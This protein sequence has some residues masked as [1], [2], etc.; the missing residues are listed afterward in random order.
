MAYT[1]ELPKDKKTRED[2][3]GNLI[4][5]GK[6]NRNQY[7][8][9]WSIA[10]HYLQGV[11]NFTDFDYLNGEVSYKLFEDL[12][13]F[14]N[15]SGIEH[16]VELIVNKFQSQAGRLMGMDFAPS[17]EPLN[18]GIESG[19]NAIVAETILRSI[20]NDRKSAQLKFEAITALLAY[21]TIGLFP[22]AAEENT[23]FGV[24][25]APPWE[26]LP[27]PS[28]ARSGSS[29]R[30]I[31]RRR[32]TPLQ[33]VKN[34][35]S[36]KGKHI[37]W[38]EVEKFS[39]QKGEIT[40]GLYS[41]SLLLNETDSD[42]GLP[43]KET[44]DTKKAQDEIVE[45]A[46]VWMYSDDNHLKT[47]TQWVGGLEIQHVDY[48]QDDTGVGKLYPA[49]SI[50]RYIDT[51]SFW[52]RGFVELL[53]PTNENIEIMSNT[54]YNNV[55]QID[56]F[57]ILCL[58]SSM[59]INESILRHQDGIKK[60][61]FEPDY[62]VPQAKPFKISP[63]NSG[64]APVKVMNTAL[65]FM[66]AIANQPIELMR[67]DAPGRA[68]SSKSLGFLMESAN[69]P[70]TPS[71]FSLSSSVSDIYRFFLSHVRTTWTG[72]EEINMPILN[73]NISGLEIDNKTGKL[74]LKPNSIPHPDEV[75]VS[76]AS[77]KPV[78]Q[79]QEIMMLQ[80]QM[81]GGVITPMEYRIEMRKRNLPV[82]VA[83]EQEWQNYRKQTIENMRQ[84]NDGVTPN[85]V[86]VS[87]IDMHEVHLY[88]IDQFMAR[89]EFTLASPSVREAF[90][91]HRNF[92]LDG[93]G[94]MP[95]GAET[96][97]EA[98]QS[99]IEYRQEAPE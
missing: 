90:I 79:Q 13:E 19:K 2:V 46:E 18:I 41:E 66:D 82:P 14:G 63:T 97:E 76:I 30:G 10:H 83:N 60:I 32:N 80:E 27:V 94:Q 29:T 81:S 92:H 3:I 47:Y 48:E 87:D 74:T 64:D 4:S 8:V 7:L 40:S 98:A 49:C 17:V 44:I 65:A 68:D 6:Q 43:R 56:E 71:A 99:Y 75:K 52:G 51:G 9:R 21:G 89:P 54:L 28:T 67:G 42:L 11:R 50:A 78:N 58:P 85:K 1:I 55:K 96:I 16:K 24:E 91:A 73:D 31:I 93:L 35:Q 61:Y 72:E 12:S 86:I 70:I 36:V 62:A 38:D 77:S 15:A 34:L 69:T 57:G 53:I 88:S 59:G 5:I 39:T 37:N 25:V 26:I 23:V 84:F 95:Q 22:W 33:W 45:F 20:F